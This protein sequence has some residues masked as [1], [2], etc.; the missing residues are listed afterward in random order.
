MLKIKI[1]SQEV[2]AQEGQSVLKAALSAGIY[3]PHLCSHPD[4]DDYKCFS[5][6]GELKPSEVIYQGCNSTLGVYTEP[7]GNP[8]GKL[9]E[10]A[11]CST[12]HTPFYCFR[13]PYLITN[14]TVT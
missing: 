10:R 13:L 1:N 7:F 5:C 14:Q 8:Q 2:N 9:S 4:L 12:L 6:S 11:L 3:I